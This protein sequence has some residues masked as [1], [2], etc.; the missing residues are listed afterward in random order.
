[1]PDTVSDKTTLYGRNLGLLTTV[2]MWIRLARS[3]Q[4]V[5][6]IPHVRGSEMLRIGRTSDPR[7]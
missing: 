5:L 4:L 2:N 7:A 6:G 1:M 3:H